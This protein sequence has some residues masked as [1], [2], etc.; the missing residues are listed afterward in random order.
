MMP[1]NFRF[2]IKWSRND[3]NVFSWRGVRGKIYFA[4]RTLKDNFWQKKHMNLLLV[5]FVVNYQLITER[6][7]SYWISL[8]VTYINLY[9]LQIW[10][11]LYTYL[12]T[13]KKILWKSQKITI[14]ASKSYPCVF[15]SYLLFWNLKHFSS[16][17]LFFRLSFDFWASIYCA[18]FI[19]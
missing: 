3:S 19:I 15:V 11:R 16:A 7:Q 13:K 6:F 17:P 2:G 8:L 10:Y 1:I 5:D 12:V 14:K 18:N 4:S 9:F